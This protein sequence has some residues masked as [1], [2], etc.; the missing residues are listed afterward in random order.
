MESV[1]ALDTTKFI[2]AA[3]ARGP[4]TVAEAQAMLQ[5]IDRAAKVD[6]VVRLVIVNDFFNKHIAFHTDWEVWGVEDYWASPLEA[7]W[8]GAGDCEDYAIAKYF[9]LLTAGIPEARMRMVYVLVMLDGKPEPHMVLAYYSTPDAK[10]LIL[11][12]INPKVLPATQRPDLTPKFSFNT[13]GLWD[14]VGAATMGDPMV[15]LS[16]W[17]D[18]IEKVRAEG[19]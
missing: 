14:G 17:R 3:K 6:E 11:D 9:S 16:K 13:A 1:E 5:M 8:K 7:L 15:R 2:E 4:R 19:F 18:L 10:P 12:N